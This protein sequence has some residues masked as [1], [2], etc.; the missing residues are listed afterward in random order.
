MVGICLIASQCK[1]ILSLEA[2]GAG[3]VEPRAIFR[4]SLA[5][6]L[7]PL[8]TRPGAFR[9]EYTPAECLRPLLVPRS[10]Y[11]VPAYQ[12][13]RRSRRG[14]AGELRRPI[15]CQSPS[16]NYSISVSAKQVKWPRAKVLNTLG[17]P[18]EV[19]ISRNLYTSNVRPARRAGCLGYNRTR[20]ASCNI[21][22][23]LRRTIQVGMK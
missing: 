20:G 9:T 7:P 4:P 5:P 11:R 13:A 23:S 15:P 14:L 16:R 19:F 17:H 8:Q 3:T 18:D 12:Q 2:G 6:S 10:G 1:A 22:P 21:R